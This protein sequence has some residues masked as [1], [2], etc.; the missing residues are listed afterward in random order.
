MNSL[1]RLRQA[2]EK[3]DTRRQFDSE[4]W[5]VVCMAQKFDNRSTRKHQATT[6]DIDQ[7]DCLV[8]GYYLIRMKTEEF[9]STVFCGLIPR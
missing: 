8:R 9:S 3:I 6:W 7:S 5:A 2:L 4:D 1:T